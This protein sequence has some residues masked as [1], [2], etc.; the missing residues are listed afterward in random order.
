MRLKLFSIVALAVLAALWPVLAQ[1]RG[2]IVRLPWKGHAQ[3]ASMVVPPGDP[4]HP[5][6]CDTQ[7]AALIVGA[8]L[9]TLLGQFSVRQSH[10]L[11]ENGAFSSGEFEFTTTAGRT[12]RGQYFGQLVPTF[13]PPPNTP[14]SGGL[15]QGSVC[16]SDGDAF[17]RIVDD[18]ASGDYSPALGILNLVT[19]DGTIF[20]DY[21][22]GVGR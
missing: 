21:A 5:A 4:M 1:G 8:G 10:C 3:S 16:V 12:I 13:P 14:P 17:A 7:P 2:H 18:C 6:R 22:L 9:T 20:I 15:I 19:G 11:G